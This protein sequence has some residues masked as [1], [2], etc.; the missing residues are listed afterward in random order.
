MSLLKK[1]YFEQK[2]IQ[3]KRSDESINSNYI[4]RGEDLYQV[5]DFFYTSDQNRFT[6][7]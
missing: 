3:R 7:K 2:R 1:R 4:K 6:F 5:S